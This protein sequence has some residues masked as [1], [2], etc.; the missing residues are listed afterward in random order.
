MQPV[1]SCFT[2]MV[3][4]AQT[5]DVKV[6]PSLTGMVSLLPWRPNIQSKH[7]NHAWK[8]LDLLNPRLFLVGHQFHH[9]FNE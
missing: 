9:A 7:T 6:I 5:N 1:D 3:L 4:P 8:L 2:L